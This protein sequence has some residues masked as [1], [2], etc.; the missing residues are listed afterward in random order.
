MTLKCKSSRIFTT[1]TRVP[2]F[3]FLCIAII[4]VNC[5]VRQ[6]FYRDHRKLAYEVLLPILFSVLLASRDSLAA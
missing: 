2:A 4:V 6:S 3:D 1:K 5:S